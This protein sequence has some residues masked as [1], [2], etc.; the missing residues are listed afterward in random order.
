[1][2][3]LGLVWPCSGHQFWGFVGGKSKRNGNFKSWKLIP[4][5]LTSNSSPKPGCRKRNGR[6]FYTQ[7][8]PAVGT[9][10]SF[11]FS[12]HSALPVQVKAS[13]VSEYFTN[14]DYFGLN[15]SPPSESRMEMG[16]KD[17][18]YRCKEHME[19]RDWWTEL[20]RKKEIAPESTLKMYILGFVS[21]KQREV[22]DRAPNFPS[23]GSSWESFYPVL[24]WAELRGNKPGS[25]NPGEDQAKQAT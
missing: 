13:K 16:Q 19:H 3:G 2:R 1:M 7:L 23:S 17:T 8:P 21:K 4:V 10:I 18:K 20:E 14:S 6:D 5:I 15:R 25:N 22:T 12:A 11:I 24:V 9:K